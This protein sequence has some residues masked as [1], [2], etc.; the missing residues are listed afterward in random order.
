MKIFLGSDHAG[1]KL[2][3]EV[4]NFLMEQGHDVEDCGAKNYDASDDYPDFIGV[5]AKK[6]SENPGSMG[7]VFGKSGGGEAI[8]A[9]KIKGI[10]AVLAVNEENVKLGREHNDANI[11]SFGSIFYDIETVKN[12]AKLFLETPF[13]N[14]ERHVRRIKKIAELENN[15]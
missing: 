2:K 4:K 14:E 12:L 15:Q 11:L 8:I 9:N 1:F 3:E 7:I 10:R 13:S 6:V 5:A